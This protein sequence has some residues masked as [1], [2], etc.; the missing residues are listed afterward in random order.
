LPDLDPAK[1]G[2]RLTSVVIGS[3]QRWATIGGENYLEG[4]LVRPLT[5]DGKPAAEVEFLLTRVEQHEVELQ[6]NGKRYKL[7][8]Q[9][10]EL[11]PGDNIN[12]QRHN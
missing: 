6:R 4:E 10:P 1:A 12:P 7:F 3:R 8:L 5:P 9:K 2:L 11:A